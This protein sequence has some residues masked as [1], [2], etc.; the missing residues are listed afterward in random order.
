MFISREQ[1]NKLSCF[2]TVEYNIRSTEILRWTCM[3]L[4]RKFPKTSVL[5]KK[6]GCRTTWR[7]RPCW[8][9]EIQKCPRKQM[10][11]KETRTQSPHCDHGRPWEREWKR[12]QGEGIFHIFCIYLYKLTL[13][14]KIKKKN[15][16]HTTTSVCWKILLWQHKL[17]GHWKVVYKC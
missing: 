2:H 1:L 15:S 7:A 5:M 12:K 17:N 16:A 3:C 10:H 9:F 6:T 4:A 11:I 8:W 14:D 13:K